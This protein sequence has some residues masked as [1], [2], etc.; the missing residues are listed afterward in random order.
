MTYYP[1][2]PTPQPQAQP[3]ALLIEGLGK[4]RTAAL[5][6]IISSL[7]TGL[8]FTLVLM[9]GGLGSPQALIAGG[10]GMFIALII[11]AILGLIALFA[12]LIPAFSRLRDYNPGEFGTPSKLIKIGYAG[13]LI[14]M[15]IGGILIAAAAAMGAATLVFAGAGLIIVAAIL[16]FIGLIGLIIGVFRLKGATGEGIFTAAGILFII[17]IFISILQFIAWILVFVGA[18]S[19]RNKLQ[20]APAPTAPAPPAAPPPPPPPPS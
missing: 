8:S 6:F 4:L 10:I 12:F 2:A 16:L 9:G 11:G 5:L 17:G 13:G 1:A 20:R 3:T 18:G 7:L 19:A 14:L 15:I